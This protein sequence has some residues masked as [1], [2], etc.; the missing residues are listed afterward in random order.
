MAAGLLNFDPDL[1]EFTDEEKTFE[2]NGVQMHYAGSYTRGEN[3]IKIFHKHTQ[4]STVAGTVAHEI[5]HRKLDA[6]RAT[7]RDQFKDMMADPGLPPD[8]NGKYWWQKAGGHETVMSADGTLRAPFD[9][10]YPVYDFWE[11]NVELNRDKMRRDDGVT[12]Y[13]MEYWKGFEKNELSI[14]KPFHETIAEMSRLKF[15]QGKLSG[16]KQWQQ[17]YN[18]MEKH[19]AEMT[20][21]ERALAQ[22]IGEKE[23]W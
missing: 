21:T 1:I 8:P 12:P 15:E 22:P 23:Y 2:L 4:L 3:K 14:D 17:L 5:G 9:K 19:W 16:S 18:F 6:L 10:K 7:Y 13:S 20:P 11:R